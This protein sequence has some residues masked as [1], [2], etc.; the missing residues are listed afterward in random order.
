MTA[1]AM[2]PLQGIRM[3]DLSRVLAGP[4]CTRLLADLDAD[5]VKVERPNNTKITMS[6]PPAQGGAFPLIGN[7]LKLSETPVTYRL[8]PPRLGEH[9]DELLEELLGLTAR[10][11]DGLRQ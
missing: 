6:R 2:G 3:L 1:G 7:P 9:T 8:P 10:D 5:V 4:S 11:R